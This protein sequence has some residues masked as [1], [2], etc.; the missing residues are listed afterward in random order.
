MLFFFGYVP[1]ELARLSP[2]R[3]G[4]RGGVTRRA[5]LSRA[6]DRHVALRQG[7]HGY[8]G[9]SDL[10]REIRAVLSERAEVAVPEIER[11]TPSQDGSQKLVLWLGD[12]ARIQ[13]VLM[14][15]DDRLTLC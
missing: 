9:M 13:S 3:A 5:P 15:D 7:R 10:P 12:G 11:R 2:P 4:E 6:P 1:P 8:R 14:P